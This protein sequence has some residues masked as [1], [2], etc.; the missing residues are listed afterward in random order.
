MSGT[1]V[2]HGDGIFPAVERSQESA[3]YHRTTPR[4]PPNTA[5]VFSSFEGAG[6]GEETLEKCFQTVRIL[7]E[8]TVT[9]LKCEGAGEKMGQLCL[10]LVPPTGSNLSDM[11]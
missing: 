9:P 7:S 8:G 10:F 5:F 1:P 4:L 6:G 2:A 11:T 3:A